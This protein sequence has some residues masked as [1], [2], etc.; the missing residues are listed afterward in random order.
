[1][2]LTKNLPQ[3]K[4]KDTW[5]SEKEGGKED[6]DY[7]LP[8]VTPGGT[9]VPKLRKAGLQSVTTYHASSLQYGYRLS[10]R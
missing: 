6:T 10:I 4:R 5:E 8:F 7:A 9:V 2:C 3:Y 1:M